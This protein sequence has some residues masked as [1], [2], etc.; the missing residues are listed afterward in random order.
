MKAVFNWVLE[1]LQEKSTW[2]GA[3]GLLS[4]IG[5]FVDPMVTNQIVTTA[6]GVAGL[7]AVI[8]KEKK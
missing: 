4:S 5:V 6:V 8:S 7:V 2:Y 1:R 3:I